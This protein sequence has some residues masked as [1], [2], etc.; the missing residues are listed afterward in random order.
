M[1]FLAYT[2]AASTAL[3]APLIANTTAGQQRASADEM[4]V[5]EVQ[6][7]LWSFSGTARYIDDRTKEEESMYVS[8]LVEADSRSEALEMAKESGR[9]QAARRG[10]VVSVN[11][12]SLW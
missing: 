3:A 12:R 11:I 1:K 9:A 6:G 7:Q 10:R 2:L 5:I 8:G 4:S